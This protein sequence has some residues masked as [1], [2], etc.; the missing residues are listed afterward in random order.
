M[1]KS[2]VFLFLI[3][4]NEHGAE[5]YVKKKQFNNIRDCFVEMEKISHGQKQKN[6]TGVACGTRDSFIKKG[7]L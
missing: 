6:L 2:V 7:K 5:T 1:V 3:F 4:S